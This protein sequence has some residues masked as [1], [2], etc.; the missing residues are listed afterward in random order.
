MREIRMHKHI[1]QGLPEVE[2]RSRKIVQSQIM[3]QLY[4]VTAKYIIGQKN[5]KINDKKVLSYGGKVSKHILQFIKFACKSSEKYKK[6]QT[7][8]MLLPRKI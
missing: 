5:D 6:T 7:K 3:G 8:T 4:S 1:C 2:L